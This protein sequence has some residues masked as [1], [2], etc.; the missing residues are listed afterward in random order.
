MTVCLPDT[1]CRRRKNGSSATFWQ[2]FGLLG[3]SNSVGTI[4]ASGVGPTAGAH[5]GHEPDLGAGCRAATT[6]RAFATF[7]VTSYEKGAAFEPSLLRV[8]PSL[9]GTP[10]EASSERPWRVR[11]QVRRQWQGRAE[12]LRFMQ[13]EGP[14]FSSVARIKRKSSTRDPDRTVERPR[15]GT[16]SMP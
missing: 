5:H 15:R 8:S 2:S 7:A 12:R 14:Q 16:Y 6:V 4:P 1:R 3:A 9:M 13:T 10:L 11:C